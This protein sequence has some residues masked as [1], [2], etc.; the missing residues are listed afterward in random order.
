MA[1]CSPACHIC[2]VIDRSPEDAAAVEAALE[3]LA[4]AL[5]RLHALEPPANPFYRAKIDLHLRADGQ[6]EARGPEGRRKGVAGR[7]GDKGVRAPDLAR[8]SGPHQG[9]A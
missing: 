7:P 9:L 1:Q 6:G 2:D 8:G 4:G 3:D 5:A